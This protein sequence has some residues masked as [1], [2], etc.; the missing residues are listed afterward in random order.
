MTPKLDAKDIRA[1]I[2]F[3]L[4]AWCVG[5]L[6][7]IWISAFVTAKEHCRELGHNSY[8]FAGNVIIC[9]DVTKADAR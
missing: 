2:T 4:I 7:G 8:R 5:W 6:F 3:M 9:V 1:V